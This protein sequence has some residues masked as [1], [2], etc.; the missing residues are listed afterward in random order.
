MGHGRELV[1]SHFVGVGVLSIVSLNLGKV[2][3]EDSLSV[4]VFNFAGV[5]DAVLGFPG[6]EL[7]YFRSLRL[8]DEE[9]CSDQCQN[10]GDMFT[11]H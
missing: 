8:T 4:D 9:S 11:L 7:R 3:K 1:K 6:L 10:D 5:V 2:L